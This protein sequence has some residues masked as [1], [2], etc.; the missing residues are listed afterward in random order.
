MTGA[1]AIQDP[2]G[3]EPKP[4]AAVY[5]NPAPRRGDLLFKEVDRRVVNY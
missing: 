3:G 1:A 2:V 4:G 5:D